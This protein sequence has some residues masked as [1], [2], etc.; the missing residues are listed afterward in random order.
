MTRLFLLALTLLVGCGRT[1]PSETCERQGMHIQTQDGVSN[2]CQG[3]GEE[4]QRY[5][6]M[7]ES[8]FQPVDLDRFTILVASAASPWTD[9][10]GEQHAAVTNWTQM[11]LSN[12]LWTYGGTITVSE[13]S[14]RTLFAHELFHVKLGPDSRNHL[15]PAWCVDL[16]PWEVRNNLEDERDY[17]GCGALPNHISPPRCPL[18]PW[19][20]QKD[21]EHERDSP[22]CITLSAAFGKTWTG[23]TTVTYEHWGSFGSPP[24]ALT[25]T[26]V[27]NTVTVTGL[28][29]PAGS[30]TIVARRLGSSASWSG[31]LACPSPGDCFITPTFTSVS[32]TLSTDETTLNVTGTG[33]AT[34]SGTSCSFNDDFTFAFQGN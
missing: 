32:M 11:D 25:L 22:G 27:G 14:I 9:P 8:S 19:E 23:A 31:N 13:S 24:Y 2:R 15:E 12:G 1:Y 16:S 6:S 33:T 29:W 21:L 34:T 3:F 28:C 17:L 26:V 10:R 18:G 30:G 20:I 7:F 5:R 4:L